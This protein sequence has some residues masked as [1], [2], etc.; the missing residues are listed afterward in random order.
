MKKQQKKSQL[1]LI[2]GAILIGLAFC[3]FYPPVF[4]AIYESGRDFGRALV[5]GF[6]K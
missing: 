5:N 1:L 6:V 2:V 4:S 3:A